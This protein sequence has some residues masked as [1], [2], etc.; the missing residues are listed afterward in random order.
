MTTKRITCILCPNGCEIEVAYSG[1]PT[2]E[3]IRVDGNLC[4]RGT[5]YVL[6][7]LTDPKRT[8]T[9]SILVRGG[10]QPQASVKTACP[11]PRAA[12]LP[13]RAA[14]RTIVAD[15]P[16]A[17]GDV[18]ARDVAGTGVDAIVTRA[19]PRAVPRTTASARRA[20]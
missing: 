12:L 20:S 11:I 4:P 15:A 18:V 2:A 14:L 3:T 8:L 1:E 16:V 7:E 9:T 17:I 6:E 13:A 10:T 5:D 19:V